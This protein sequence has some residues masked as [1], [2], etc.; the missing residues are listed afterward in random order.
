[1]G[2]EGRVSEGSLTVSEG[3]SPEVWGWGRTGRG[4]GK[5][6]RRE[7]RLEAFDLGK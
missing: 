2:H 6:P 5:R 4:E 1:M 3:C 7:C